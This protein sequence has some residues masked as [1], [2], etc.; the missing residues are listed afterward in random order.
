MILSKN[1]TFNVGPLSIDG[2]LN[3]KT[4]SKEKFEEKTGFNFSRKNFLI[5]Y[6]PETIKDDLGI[7]G[8]DNLLNVLSSFPCNI[9]FTSPN[10]DKGSDIILN[11]ILKAVK[12]NKNNYFYKP[13]LGH[14]L[15]LNALLLFDCIVGNSSSG[16]IEAPLL[17]KNV[18]NIGNRQKGRYRFGKVIDVQD[19]YKSIFNAICNIDK[20]PQRIEYDFR[21]FKKNYIMKSPSHKIIKFLKNIP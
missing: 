1:N 2:L 5:T 9:L 14:H 13:S 18:I 3:L 20:S 19:D 16:I 15:Y 21:E 17:K 6:H 12:E 10:A 4:I 7:S 11:R 8:L